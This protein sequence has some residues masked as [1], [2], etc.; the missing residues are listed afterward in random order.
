MAAKSKALVCR[1]THLVTTDVEDR[2]GQPEITAARAGQNVANQSHNHIYHCWGPAGRPQTVN[3]K[4]GVPPD[5]DK[6]VNTTLGLV[7]AVSF[8][9]WSC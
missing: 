9:K 8:Y 6:Y 2:K 3:V 1:R 4:K 5:C 7:E